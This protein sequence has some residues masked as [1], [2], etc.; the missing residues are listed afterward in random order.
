MSEFGK[1]IRPV[2]RKRTLEQTAR[3]DYCTS[4]GYEYYYGDAHATG[5]A[6]ISKEV[7]PGKR[8]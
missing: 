3:A 6:Q 8:G 1:E 4:C 2:C 5:E 7:N